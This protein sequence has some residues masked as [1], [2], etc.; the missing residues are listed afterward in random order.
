VPAEGNIYSNRGNEAGIECF[1]LVI[2][3]KEGKMINTLNGALGLKIVQKGEAIHFEGH[4]NETTVSEIVMKKTDA[5]EL[6]HTGTYEIHGQG[7]GLISHMP[8]G[9]NLFFIPPNQNNDLIC[10]ESQVFV[11]ELKKALLS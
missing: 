4:F 11:R 2:K 7:G 5:A 1:N 10:V 6:V 9:V 3:L 8:Q